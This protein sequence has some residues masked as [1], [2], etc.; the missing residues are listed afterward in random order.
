MINWDIKIVKTRLKNNFKIIN[1]SINDMD[2]FEKK[3]LPKKRAFTKNTWY[4]WYDWLSN[5]IHKPIIESV[6]E[7]KDQIIS[8]LNPGLE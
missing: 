6:G 3:E 2:K 5:Y 8:I 7:V 4:D 1:I